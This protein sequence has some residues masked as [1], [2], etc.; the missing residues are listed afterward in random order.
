MPGNL[1]KVVKSFAS[2]TGEAI[3]IEGLAVSSLASKFL[4]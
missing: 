1:L 4:Q 2:I 3:L